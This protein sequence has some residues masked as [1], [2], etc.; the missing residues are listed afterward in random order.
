VDLSGKT[1]L[2]T[3]AAGDGV[4]A[5][6]CAAIVR[7]G[8]RLLVNDVDAGALERAAASHGAE[9]SYTTD[10][11]DEAQVEDMFARIQDEFGALGG[12]VNNAGVGL[13]KPVDQ[14][15]TSEYD[16]LM[17]VDQRGVWLAS[18][19]FARMTGA[20]GDRSVVNV[21]S[22]HAHSTMAGYAVYASAKAGV[23]G[24]TRGL[25][26]DLGPRGIRCNAVAPGYVHSRQNVALISGWSDDPEA[27]VR[28]HT[29]SQQ[30]IGR[31]IHPID[32]GW[33]AAFL[34]SDL[35]RAVTGQVI[36]VDAGTTSLLYGM[37]FR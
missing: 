17:A 27:W 28:Q 16:R 11:S 2:V 24:L 20:S 19:A 30:V 3:G 15:T 5:G 13:N 4:G 10:V 8:G 12:L 36:R 22:V 9:A 34:L 14:V 21:T 7:A 32:C 25:A 29:A 35:S 6:V 37:D 1:I 33:V 26:V 23:E 31:E 18:R